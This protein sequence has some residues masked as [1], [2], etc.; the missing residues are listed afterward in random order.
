MY[1]L[2]KP[3]KNY[4]K[5][6]VLCDFITSY[7]Y[8]LLN[9]FGKVTTFE[10]GMETGHAEKC[11]FIQYLS[12]NRMYYTGTLMTNGTHFEGEKRA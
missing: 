6:F 5:T 9:Y 1:D 4:M 10:G 2:N 3:K 12:V 11:F 8:N 7:A